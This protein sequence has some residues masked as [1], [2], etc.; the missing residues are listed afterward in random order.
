MAA[1]AAQR[2]CR[3]GHAR[4]SAADGL[5]QS[6]GATG[7]D[8]EQTAAYNSSAQ[9]SQ[10]RSLWQRIKLFFTGDKLDRKRLA[11]LGLGAVASYG[12]V[13]N[14]TYGTG[15]AVSWIG[16]VRQFGKSPFMPGQWK[17]FLAFY[18]GEYLRRW[19]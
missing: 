9:Q 14:V 2:Q 12:F 8:A 11:A 6:V 3:P 1:V 16:F 15:L 5:P 19:P 7:S 10:S 18:A 17:A 4:A 13:S